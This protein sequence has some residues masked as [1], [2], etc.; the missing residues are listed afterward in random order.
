MSGILHLFFIFAQNF[1][2]MIRKLYVLIL[3]LLVATSLY[4]LE[5]DEIRAVWLTT[6]Y[7]LDWPSVAGTTPRVIERQKQDLIRILDQLAEV[8]INTVFFQS[9][10]RGEVFYDSSIEQQ[11][12]F[13]TGSNGVKS[14]FDPLAFAV[15]E[16][17]R[18][19]MTCHAWMVCMPLGGKKYIARHALDKTLARNRE[20][21]TLH[22][23][24]YFLEPSDPR[25]ADYLADIA[26]EIV[27]NYKVDGVH[28]DYI[29]YPEKA[30][31]YPD[32]QRY[33]RSGK[34][35]P[36]AQWRRDNITH[37]VYTIYNKVK[38][39]NPDVQLSSAPLGVYNG[40]FG[41]HY[42]GWNAFEA[43]YQ[44]VERW[45]QEDK[46]DFIAPM[47]YYKGAMFY[48]FVIDWCKRS[49]GKPVVPGLGIY[50]L[51]EPGSNWDLNEIE[52]QIWWSRHLG[53][54]GYALFRAGNLLNDFP[55]LLWRIRYLNE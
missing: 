17:H 28:L 50:R 24:E 40:R 16:C 27:S 48:P 49:Y 23:G 38:S 54:S 34:K 37:I 15:E 13:L 42:Y 45:L 33:A 11:S 1:K 29:R 5:S 44:E 36:L 19:K 20:F 14:D 46:H 8:G 7:R 52:K 53:A 35:K 18:R 32:Q 31:S 3:S 26:G 41:K 47:M 6:N 2:Y 25:T 21:V 10:I 43:G 9:R 22:D 4:A 55:A 12:Q 39:V 51:N 30:A